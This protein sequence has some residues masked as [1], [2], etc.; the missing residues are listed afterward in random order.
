MLRMSSDASRIFLYIDAFQMPGS[1][2]AVKTV[3]RALMR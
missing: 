2:T 1:V 3:T